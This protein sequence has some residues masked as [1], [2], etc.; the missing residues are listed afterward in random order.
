MPSLHSLIPIIAPIIFVALWCLVCGIISRGG[1]NKLAKGHTA[2]AA[3][4]GRKLAWQ[5]L[6][7][8]RLGR[9]RRC[10]TFRIS[11]SGLRISVIPIFAVGHPPLFFQWSEVRY[12]KEHDGLFTKQYLYELGTPLAG[13]IL[14]SSKVHQ[15]IASQLQLR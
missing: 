1:W 15:A 14:V 2:F 10:V 11:E 6:S 7:F 8:K 5:N 9:Y 4:E 13:R 3:P 12:R